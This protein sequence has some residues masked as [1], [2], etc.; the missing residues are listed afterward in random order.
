M[1]GETFVDH[2]FQLKVL[3]NFG[4]EYFRP[5]VWRENVGGAGGYVKLFFV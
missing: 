2:I 5:K 1:S 3:G 4:E